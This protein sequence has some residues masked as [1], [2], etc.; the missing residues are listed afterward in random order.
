GKRT[1]LHIRL[2]GSMSLDAGH[3]QQPKIERRERALLALL[4]LRW[5]RPT[6]RTRLAE[7]LWPGRSHASGQHCLSTAL[8]RLRTG[9]ATIHG[10][11]ILPSR[12]EVSLEVPPD[13]EVDLV[14]FDAAVTTVV[15][16]VGGRPAS[17]LT[18]DEAGRLESGLALYQGELLEGFDEEWVFHE[19]R[20]LHEAYLAGLQ[21]LGAHFAQA[22]AHERAC[23]YFDEIVRWDPLREDVHRSLMEVRFGQGRRAQAIDQYRACA[24]V[25][26]AELG[27]DAAAETR[28]LLAEILQADAATP[29]AAEAQN[30]HQ[31]NDLGRALLRI[32]AALKE[33]AGTCAW[34]VDELASRDGLPTPPDDGSAVTRAS[35][36]AKPGLD[37]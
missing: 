28:R 34:L 3:A 23:M 21:L 13:V 27:V 33:A 10:P 15:K 2:L 12:T 5:P 25:L 1:M 22:G 16:A 36:P 26:Q 31:I 35:G 4:L 17:S 8:W 29:A 14:R 30:G 11:D 37:C 24:R 9:L 19:R 6:S 18:E 7:T 32:S 20:R